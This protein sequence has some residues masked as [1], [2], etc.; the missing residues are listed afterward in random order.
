MEKFHTE[1]LL[2]FVLRFF[3]F[4]R[5]TLLKRRGFMRRGRAGG[6]RETRKLHGNEGFT[7]DQLTRSSSFACRRPGTTGNKYLGGGNS[8]GGACCSTEVRRPEERDTLSP[9]TLSREYTYT[10]ICGCQWLCSY[11]SFLLLHGDRGPALEPS[12][13]GGDEGPLAT[14]RSHERA[15]CTFRKRFK[16][17]AAF[18]GETFH[19]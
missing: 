9:S 1:V 11:L 5:S 6:K 17:N 2:R 12:R 7:R 10:R 15:P 13:T 3:F 18:P 8:G 14:P 16:K 4:S 19:R